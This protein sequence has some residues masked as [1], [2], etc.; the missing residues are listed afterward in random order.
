MVPREY[1]NNTHY[2]ETARSTQ[3][4]IYQ[5]IWGAILWIASH[6][7]AIT[8]TET[9]ANPWL[10]NPGKWKYY[11]DSTN[12]NISKNIKADYEKYITA[13]KEIILSY[14]IIDEIN[15]KTALAKDRSKTHEDKLRLEEAKNHRIGIIKN[16]I[17]QLQLL[18]QYLYYDYKLFDIGQGVE[19]GHNEKFSYGI[20]GYFG[21]LK[22]SYN[23][24]TKIFLKYKIF[25]KDNYVITIKPNFNLGKISNMVAIETIFGSSKK[26]SRK[27]HKLETEIFQYS[28][29]GVTKYIGNNPITNR[30]GYQLENCVGIKLKTDILLLIQTINEIQPGYMGLF[31]NIVKNHFKISKEIDI[32]DSKLSFNIGYF[33]IKSIS[34]KKHLGSGYG[35]GIWI[36]I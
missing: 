4:S 24:N 35:G 5:W 10:P 25:Q 23:S 2:D 12:Y 6:S 14:K 8:A 15:L 32:N 19:Y 11:F 3:Q 13:E 27:K 9:H 7:L 28:G 17:A 29:I 16:H 34:G 22:Y 33:T 31:S 20:D 21:K 26:I 30:L 18:K 36:E 1:L